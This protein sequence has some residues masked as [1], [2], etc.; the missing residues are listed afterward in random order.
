MVALR[1][2]H[3]SRDLGVVCHLDLPHL[4]QENIERRRPHL[5]GTDCDTQG[6]ATAGHPSFFMASDLVSVL[7]L[8]PNENLDSCKSQ[9]VTTH[10]QPSSTLSPYSWIAIYLSRIEPRLAEREG[11]HPLIVSDGRDK[12]KVHGG[13]LPPFVYPIHP[14]LGI[15]QQ[16]TILK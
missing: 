14:E 11:G 3:Q 15:Q 5:L 13:I 2:Y 12:G 1:L 8:R 6:C 16:R 9:E 7:S 4:V 10:L